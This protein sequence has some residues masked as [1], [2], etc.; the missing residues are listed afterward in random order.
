MLGV[1]LAELVRLKPRGVLVGSLAVSSDIFPLT[2]LYIAA[3]ILGKDGI[4][5][6]LAF[7][8]GLMGISRGPAGFGG[9]VAWMGCVLMRG[10]CPGDAEG[11]LRAEKRAARLSWLTEETDWDLL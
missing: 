5:P 11:P 6:M 4:A 1:L 7:T 3:G 9:C 10:S 2:G 8:F